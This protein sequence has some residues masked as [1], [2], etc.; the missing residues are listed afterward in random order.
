MKLRNKIDEFSTLEGAKRWANNC[1]KLH[2]VVLGD[3]D[4]FWVVCGS[5]FQTLIKNGYEAAK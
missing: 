2:L 3:N 1:N 5:D 4:K